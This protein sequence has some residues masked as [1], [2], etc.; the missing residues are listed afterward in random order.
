MKRCYYNFYSCTIHLDTIESFIYPTGIQ[1]DCSKNVKICIKIYMRCAPHVSVFYNH[2][3]GATTYICFA[4]VT[5]ISNQ[6]KYA[7]ILI[8]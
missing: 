2:H 3:Q 5:G 8:V 6:L 7:V 1:L 4:K